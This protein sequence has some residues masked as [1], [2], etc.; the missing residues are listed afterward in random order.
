MYLIFR[1]S[2]N[3]PLVVK[4]INRVLTNLEDQTGCVAHVFI[5][6]VD[7]KGG[8]PSIQKYV[9]LATIC[10][11]YP[12]VL[13]LGFVKGRL[14]TGWDSKPSMGRSGKDRWRTSSGNGQFVPSEVCP[15]YP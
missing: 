4:S 9:S 5:A 7:P 10:T 12:H 3:Q 2:R 8:A 11:T 1:L 14:S 15:V 13:L 6:S